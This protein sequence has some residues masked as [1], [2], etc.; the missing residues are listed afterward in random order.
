MIEVT[1]ELRKI[2]ATDYSQIELRIMAQQMG[3]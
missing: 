3:I 2:V 1:D